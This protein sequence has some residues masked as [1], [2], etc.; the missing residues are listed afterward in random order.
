MHAT[1][2]FLLISICFASIE[3]SSSSEEWELL[4]E[5]EDSVVIEKADLCGFNHDEAAVVLEEIANE[6][7]NGLTGMSP[8]VRQVLDENGITDSVLTA[9]ST[10]VNC[11]RRGLHSCRQGVILFVRNLA[12]LWEALKTANNSQIRIAL[13][14]L[15]N[16]PEDVG[17]DVVPSITLAVALVEAK[18]DQKD[19]NCIIS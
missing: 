10:L 12:D 2:L 1:F 11:G 17:Q 13:L 9:L 19:K 15:R 8:F 6:V 3:E 14:K 5:E 16:G 7:G 4:S 18:L